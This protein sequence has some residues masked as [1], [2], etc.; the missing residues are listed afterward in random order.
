M[1]SISKNSFIVFVIPVFNDWKS[2]LRLIH[3]LDIIFFNNKSHLLLKISIIIVDDSSELECSID[4]KNIFPNIAFYVIRLP[5]NLGHQRAI[6]VG[7]LYASESLKPDAVVFMDSDG[8]DSPN[9]VLLLLESY[10]SKPNS[11]SIAKRTKRSESTIFIIFYYIYLKLFKL[12]TGTSL[13][14]GNF[15]LIPLN[16]LN[17]LLYDGNLW[18]H[19]AATIN[20]SR[21]NIE[22]I[23]TQRGQRYSGSS[24]MNFTSLI[25]HGLSAMSVYT[26][27]IA[28]RLILVSSSIV[29]LSALSILIILYLKFFTLFNIPGWTSQIIA[30]FFLISLTSCGFAFSLSLFILNSRKQINFSLKRDGYQF[31]E[32]LKKWNLN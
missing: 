5:V 25:M 20:R 9:D 28:I 16:I 2:L 24:H 4:F 31:L 8:E 10:L 26:D 30:I 11:I 21:F 6:S 18:N 27:I 1:L 17:N 32:N 12:F 15:S 14:Y 3:E 13:P 22:M 19:F 29:F 7:A 23:A